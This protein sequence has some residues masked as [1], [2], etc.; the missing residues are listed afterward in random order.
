MLLKPEHYQNTKTSSVHCR[1]MWGLSPQQLY[2]DLIL[3]F[4]TAL[5]SCVN[6]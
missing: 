5:H 6:I 1:A 3:Y 4:L 2:I